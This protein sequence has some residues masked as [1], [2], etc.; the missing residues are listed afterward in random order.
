MAL[1]QTTTAPFV[2]KLK[3][4]YIKVCQACRLNYDGPND[5]TGL[6]VT[7]AEKRIISNPSTGVQFTKESNSHYHAR[8]TCLIQANPFFTGVDLKI[9]GDVKAALTIYQKIYLATCLH[10]PD[11]LPA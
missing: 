9:P 7:R 11:M 10:V 5:T 3:N 6:V 2:L 8:L 4:N 1:N